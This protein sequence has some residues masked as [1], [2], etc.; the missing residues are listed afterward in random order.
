[1]RHVPLPIM[2][3]N[4]VQNTLKSTD[5]SSKVL[6]NSGT[7]ENTD[8]L[9]LEALNGAITQG[10]NKL[11]N[12]NSD[13]SKNLSKNLSEKLTENLS[14]KLS[15]KLT[16]NLTGKLTENKIDAETFQSILSGGKVQ[17]KT[18]VDGKK[19]NV[20]DLTSLLKN[21]DSKNMIDSSQLAMFNKNYDQS[22][23][24]QNPKY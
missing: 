10:D 13:Q 18:I 19:G 2:G 3:N 6:N 16:E 9:F 5:K 22:K 23:L 24:I 15:G 20:V 1:M 7:G 14:A 4:I 11:K 21:N 8:Q 17:S 12:I